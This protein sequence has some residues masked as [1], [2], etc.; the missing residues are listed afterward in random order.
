MN[1]GAYAGTLGSTLEEGTEPA[2]TEFTRLISVLG[3]GF[4]LEEVGMGGG[5][6]EGEGDRRGR[7]R[8]SMGDM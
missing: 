7:T 1:P 3:G 2:W 6:G 4:A 8:E 5:L